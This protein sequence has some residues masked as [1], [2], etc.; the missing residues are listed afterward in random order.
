MGTNINEKIDD[1]ADKAKDLAD[2]AKVKAGDIAEALGEAGDNAEL[3]AKKG[4]H[5]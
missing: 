3:G 1:V 4:E 2:K 5:G